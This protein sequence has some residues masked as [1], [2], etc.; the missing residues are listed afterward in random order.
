[1]FIYFVD[2]YAQLLIFL[3]LSLSTFLIIS[4]FHKI[5]GKNKKNES[6]KYNWLLWG[7]MTILQVWDR[8]WYHW[9]TFVHWCIISPN[10]AHKRHM[11]FIAQM[12][13]NTGLP[14]NFISLLILNCFSDIYWLIRIFFCEFSIHLFCHFT[15]W[16]FYY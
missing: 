10:I 7:L 3:T 1:M 14:V 13:G 16:C 5:S 12:N 15:D 11:V 9:L 6:D 8:E 2:Y 4:F